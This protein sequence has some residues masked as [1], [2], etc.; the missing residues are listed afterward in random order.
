M[1]PLRRIL[2]LT[3]FAALAAAAH[4]Q[5]T[6]YTNTGTTA[7][8]TSSDLTIATRTDNGETW[9]GDPSTTY[10]FGAGTATLNLAALPSHTAVTL[11]FDLYMTG[12]EDGN[13]PAGS[14]TDPWTLTQTGSSSS[15]LIATSFANYSG[16]G[17]MQSFGGSNGAGG[18]LVAP[19]V[20][21]GA[22]Y[23]ARTGAS[24]ANH[25]GFGTS[26]YGDATYS[27]SFTFASTSPTQ[28]FNFISALN[29]GANN[30]GWGLDN[31]VVKV[32]P[33]PTPEPATF[34]AL[35]VGAI[36]VLRRRRKA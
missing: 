16:G 20:Y 21:G 30:E 11:S 36:A 4:S 32:T 3:A 33:T 35:G 6:V 27:L 2:T 7:G 31:I 15:T 8:F 19:V 28:T 24:A 10:G 18:Y 34:A 23:A 25:L 14:G 5:V 1:I 26:D 12:S 22:G 13:G 29:E 9:L 17:N